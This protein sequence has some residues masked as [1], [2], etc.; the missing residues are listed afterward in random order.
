LKELAMPKRGPL[1]ALPKVNP[2]K[3]GLLVQSK[4]TQ[5]HQA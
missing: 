5:I 4:P 2:A 3:S 1:I